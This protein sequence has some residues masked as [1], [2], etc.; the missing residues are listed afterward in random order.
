MPSEIF[1]RRSLPHWYVPNAMH[2]VTFRLAGTIPQDKIRQWRSEREAKLGREPPEGMSTG[3]WRETAH[4]QF[5][6]QYD[7][8]L[9]AQQSVSWLSEPPV[10]AL[11]RRSL[12]FHDGAKYHLFSYC[13]MPNH[14]HALLQP[15][16][17]EHPAR[18]ADWMPDEKPDSHSPLSKIMHSLKSFTANEA[19]KLLKRDDQFWQHES[20]DHWVRDEDE[21]E[22]IVNYID[23]NPVKPG[24]VAR[25]QDW[26][27]G[28]SHDRLLFDG[29]TVGWLSPEMRK[30]ALP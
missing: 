8:Y 1:T 12:Y 10:A 23:A 5:F 3:M 7:S 9:D 28:S 11:M 18:P 24:L 25:S 13:V 17:A 29:T 22:R 27:F 4:K 26:Y 21:L 15:I 16:D 30:L 6:A 20:Y 2:F 19:N 14:V